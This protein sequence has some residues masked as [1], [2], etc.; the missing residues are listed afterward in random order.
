VEESPVQAPGV[1]ECERSPAP[2]DAVIWS[3]D[4]LEVPL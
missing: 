4:D 1:W 2:L 3:G